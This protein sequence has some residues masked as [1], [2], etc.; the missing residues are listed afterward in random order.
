M[1][2]ELTRLDMAES[3][4]TGHKVPTGGQ[5]LA[6]YWPCWKEL[7]CMTSTRSHRSALFAAASSWL[8]VPRPGRG[9]ADF[10]EGARRRPAAN[11]SGDR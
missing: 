7:S 9:H 5:F 2:R 3:Y 10:A 8:G 1:F 11:A 6:A 4:S